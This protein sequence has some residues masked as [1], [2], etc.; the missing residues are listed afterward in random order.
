MLRTLISREREKYKILLRKTPSLLLAVLVLSIVSMNLLANKELFRTEWV[1]L[2]CGFILSWI[3]FIIMDA[4]CRAY[5]GKDAARI[6]ILA[7][8]LNL[9]LFFVFK[10][11]SLTPGM[12]G[13]YY[14]TNNLAVN[15]A[16]NNTIGGS[17]WIVLG[18][19]L[20]MTTASIVN[21]IINTTIA[22]LSKRDNYGSFAVRSF[23]STIIAQFVDNFIF[24]T[25]VSIPLFGWSV[26]QALVCSAVAA[27]FEL[28]M[29]IVFSLFGYQ[30]SKTLD[31][32][33][34]N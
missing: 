11:V 21:S 15:R 27:A 34:R 29:E 4:I 18:S 14:E 3:P 2:D 24:A 6:S 16:L 33:N 25:A 7:I 20:A 1:A 28:A 10:I 32:P 23:T 26:N 17:S 13:A 9:I 19:A 30:L 5:G 12:W 31:H 8:A 22:K